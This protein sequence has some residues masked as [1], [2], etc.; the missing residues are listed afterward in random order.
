MASL[1]TE[2]D[3]N[4]HTYFRWTIYDGKLWAA[5][6]LFR[7][8]IWF[9]S[10]VHRNAFRWSLLPE[11]TNLTYQN[12]FKNRYESSE[13]RS[14]RWRFCDSAPRRRAK[15]SLFITLESASPRNSFTQVSCHWLSTFRTYGRI[16]V[17][18]DLSRNSWS[19]L[20]YAIWGSHP[21]RLRYLPYEFIFILIIEFSF[22]FGVIF[23]CR[24][25]LLWNRIIIHIYLIKI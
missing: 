16:P 23:P 19:T 20:K 10:E 22:I 13:V 24:H 18:C 7:T 8:S 25:L 3:H 21:V 17:L 6:F 9:S 15:P 12:S 5:I 11:R 14:C 2:T 1:S 4:V